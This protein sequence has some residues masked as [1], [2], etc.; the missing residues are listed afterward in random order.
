[1]TVE[2]SGALSTGRKAKAKVPGKEAAVCADCQ[3]AA[4][5]KKAGKGG[6]LYC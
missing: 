5:T 4:T 1:M 3:E 2:G 6:G